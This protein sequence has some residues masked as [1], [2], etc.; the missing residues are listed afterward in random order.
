LDDG[1]L[2]TRVPIASEF[3][4]VTLA[5]EGERPTGTLSLTKQPAFQ[6]GRNHIGERALTVRD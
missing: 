4:D 1:L 2:K 6:G 3:L 5:F